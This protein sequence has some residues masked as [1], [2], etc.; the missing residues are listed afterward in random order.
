MSARGPTPRRSALRAS[1][2]HAAFLLLVAVT[3]LPASA[4]IEATASTEGEL[5]SAI[6]AANAAPP[7][8]ANVITLTDDISLTQSLPM[9][10]NNLAFAGGG[11]VIDADNAGRVFFVQA[12]VVSITDLTIANAVAAG[13]AG[14]TGTIMNQPQAAGS[15]GGGGGLGAGA[16]LFVN[17]GASVTVSNVTITGA[18]ATGGTAVTAEVIDPEVPNDVSGTGAGGGGIG[19]QG[20]SAATGDL[21]SI[22]GGGG[23]GG[24]N[25]I[26]GNS[27]G[28]S[29]GG[30]GGA[31]AF[32]AGGAGFSSGGGGGGGTLLPGAD[33]TTGLPALG[34]GAEGGTG[35]P[36][37]MAG[38][39]APGVGGGGGGGGAGG[40]G[41]TG[42]SG[43]GGGGGGSGA[44][45]GTGGDFGGGGGGGTGGPGAAGGFGGG[46]GSAGFLGPNVIG[47]GGAGGFGGGG[48][49]G[50]IGGAAGAFGGRGG[51][52]TSADGGGG[53]ALGGAVFV[54]S[55]G[56]LVITD[57]AFSGLNVTPGSTG[58]AGGA[59]PGQA[60]GRLAFVMG[61]L[62]GVSA[63]NLTLGVSAGTV[64]IND[65][66]AL[67]GAG[68]LV[69][70][71]NGVLV[72][73]GANGNYAGTVDIAAG[74]LGFGPGGSLSAQTAL[75]VSAG[76]L[77]LNDTNQTIGSLA[78]AGS[79]QLGSGDLTT[80]ALNT[81]TMFTGVIAGTGA[82]TKIGTGTMTLGGANTYTGAT[83]V[84]AGTLRF[85]GGG[86][87]AAGSAVSVSSGATLD[88]NGT[89]QTVGS[90]AGAGSVA[91]EGGSLAAGANNGS[92]LFSGTMDGAGSFTKLGTGTLTF[93]GANTYTG[94]TTVA[95][96][97]LRF[98]GGGTLSDQSAV[99]VLSG[100]TLDLNGTT[101][102]VGSLAGAGN[103]LLGT[104]A[105]I[106]GGY[107]S[108]TVYSGTMSGAGS[109]TK[110]GAGILTFAGT[111]TYTGDTTIAAGT[112]RFDVGGRLSGAT[113][114]S[115]S[116][117]ATLDLNG[118]THT[119][120]SL[121]GAGNVL[122]G[123]GALTVGTNNAST[124]FAGTISGSGGFSKVG[125]GTLTLGGLNTFAGPTTISAGSL[126][127]TGALSG[128]TAVNVA[129]GALFDIAGTTQLIG[130]LSGGGNVLLGNGVLIAG[131]SSASTL[132]AGTMSGSGSFV[133]A[134]TGTMALAGANTYTGLTAI[135]QGRLLL[136]GGSLSN[137]TTVAVA[138]GATWD[139]NGTT[140][141]I[142]G[143][144]GEGDVWLGGATLTVGSGGASSIFGGALT[145]QGALIKAGAGTLALT[146][147]NGYTGG[148]FLQGGTL[149]IGSDGSLGAAQSGLFFDGGRLAAGG[150]LTSSRPVT[151][152]REGA[153]DTNGFQVRWDGLVSGPGA[154]VK[155]GA[156]VLTLT[157]NN[158][159][160]GGTR[161]TQ[162]TLAGTTSSLRGNIVNDAVLNFDQ[163]FD[164]QYDG[165]IS[166][167]GGVL[168]SGAGQLTLTGAH[169]YAGG[170]SIVGGTLA[171]TTS[172]LRGDIQNDA[173]LIF[174][175]A[176]D[177]TFEGTLFGTGSM[178][179]TGLGT[180]NLVGAHPFRGSTLVNQGTLALNGIIGGDVRVD[181]GASFIGAG[182]VMGSLHLAG[183]LDVPRGT[184]TSLFNA[185]NA[186]P[187]A[188]D[189][190]AAESTSPSL[191]I[192]GTLTATP[193][194]V[195]RLDLAPGSGTAVGVE[196]R[197]FLSNTT[198]ELGFSDPASRST[199][200]TALTSLGGLSVN[201]ITA[202]SLNPD[203]VPVLTQDGTSVLV[204]LLNYAVPLTGAATSPNTS[205]VAR[206]VDAIKHTATGNLGQVVRELI[207]MDEPGLDRAL[208][209]LAGQVHA[210]QQWAAAIDSETFTD[211]IREEITLREHGYEDD[212]ANPALAPRAQQLRWWAQ[213]AGEHA[214]FSADGFRGAV[215][216]LGGVGGG[217]DLKR[218][219]RWLFGLGGSYSVAGLSLDGLGG[220]SD[221]QAP[222]A[223]AYSGVKLGRV[224]LN[225]GASTA[226]TSYKTSRRITFAATVPTPLGGLTLLDEGIDREAT[227]E[228]KGWV[229][230]GWSE[231]HDSL[232]VQT[233]TLDWKAGWR[234]VRFTRESW[235]ETGAGAISLA[236]PAQTLTLNE[237]DALVHL[238]K[239]S[240]AIR[241]RALFT[242]KRELFEQGSEVAMHFV[243]QPEGQFT[244][245][246]MPTGKDTITALGGLTFVT[247]SGLE[248]AVRY[249]VRHATGELRQK[250]AFRIRFR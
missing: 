131:G 147:A 182:A 96:G 207:A 169:T 203:L 141:T 108:S 150:N 184:A 243:D 5:V 218:T 190:A 1:A 75:S 84:T 104:G 126:R 197:T 9:I 194:S 113:A 78:G 56:V 111:N 144:L 188:A 39:N 242:Y 239:R 138:G 60:Q 216:N 57:G 233:W 109:L 68:L 28:S 135:A 27:D 93:G 50:V 170:T 52:G 212:V 160:S 226:K 47:D 101:Q 74:T 183:R 82:L 168:K 153:I 31:G 22:G 24:Y 164:G 125:T 215:A 120:A 225:V 33:N 201:G 202:S 71:G 16:A 208:E 43:G 85:V 122:L 222:R 173:R 209:S 23:G 154:L 44:A 2:R 79:V 247:P 124:T 185:S 25:G 119:L 156:G 17:T 112:L 49:G 29:G 174:N 76:T 224:R 140:Q 162:G 99:E 64:T 41:G 123:T 18:Q 143:L 180:L 21:G 89:A 152:N 148:T 231:Y 118:T 235:V 132:F 166:G 116:S 35:S 155:S 105:L 107:S 189:D 97:S 163:P 229:S 176:G 100:A 191:I 34:G 165:V 106:V 171:G 245:S 55:G 20:G 134:G 61:D 133:K 59:T 92:T 13:G 137:L 236:A 80:G 94:A 8:S 37:G 62:G 187:D 151:L 205:S 115:V 51:S 232:K 219:E 128:L 158:S 214:S 53:A 70:A 178:V 95:G 129:S 217:F 213:A 83:N 7:G 103:V 146:G 210:T 26:G 12:G 81:S 200:Y 73:G 193:G 159:Y 240:G 46:G 248:Y 221:L 127:V 199:T 63:G 38:G 98:V 246:G 237:A 230:D 149:L 195:I 88:L 14:G 11:F 157:G 181:Q 136:A 65:D 77:A 192:G 117:G 198:F 223:F 196:G 238:F 186:N 234:Y 145:G 36:S 179:K 19:G 177:G 54:R 6:L 204:T 91:L 110:A 244:T 4:Q 3:P 121:A 220:G 114:V 45:G 228:Q 102:T 32:G 206:A 66:D 42:N 249:E 48:G 67:A 69:K 10:S 72:L 87:V 15:P 90:L 58:G 250:L 172:S 227:S 139:L 130:S 86:S 30:G 40:A 167:A 211:M 142:E 241:P 175:Q 161:I